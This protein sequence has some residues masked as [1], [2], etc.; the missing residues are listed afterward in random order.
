M[1]VSNVVKN[2]PRALMGLALG[3][4]LGVSA[5]AAGT[6]SAQEQV[7]PSLVYRTGP[8]APGGISLAD[9]YADYFTLI[10]ERDGGING[11]KFKV[12]ECETGYSTDR[13]VEC[14]DRT[15]NEGGGATVY[16]P[17]STGIT[18]ALIEKATQDKIPVLSMGYGRTSAA[19]GRYFPYI[20]NFPSTYWNQATAIVQY[21]ANQEG[22]IEKLKGMNF[23]Y[24][25]LD[26][27]YGKEPLPTMDVMAAKFGF[28]F[29]RYPVPPASMTEQKSIWL[30]IRRQRP[31]YAIMWGWGAMNGTA[32][33]EA[34]NI[35]FPMD[36]F[37]GNWWAAGEDAV[38][39]AG[40]GGIGYKAA[41]FH[42]AGDDYDVYN[43]LKKY[44]YDTNKFAGNGDQWGRV[45]YNRGVANAIYVVEALKIAHAKYGT[46]VIT[47][48]QMQWALENLNLTDADIAKIGAA[49]LVPAVSVTCANHEGQNPAVLIQQWD[50][51]EYKII[52]D[53]I[54]AMADL[55]RPIL[56]EEAANYAKEQGITAR[57]CS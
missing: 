25:Y 7:I 49:G 44:V 29:D 2:S 56:E 34:A 27:P 55:T 12:T 13:G 48:E 10:N 8:Y 43:D 4:I 26:H 14:Y 28:S 17:W 9:G 19:D 11:V 37:I 3:T 15:K 40:Q 21:I 30:K 32:V 5:F 53:W 50:G 35:N 23:A 42:G 54:P 24:I 16:S 47:G 6:A 33:N 52:T 51:K 41:T 45:L 57:S 36:K 1:L 39:A 38:E 18:Y 31:D 22:G 46:G 20:F